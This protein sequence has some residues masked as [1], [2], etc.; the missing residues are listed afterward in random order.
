MYICI[1]DYEFQF[2]ASNLCV[3]DQ[4]QMFSLAWP[5]TLDISDHKVITCKD[6]RQ[7]KNLHFICLG[8]Q[9]GFDIIGRE[10]DKVKVFK[11]VQISNLFCLC[12]FCWY[13]VTS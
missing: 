11:C 9:E 2:C 8:P 4:L 6:L 5:T 1:Y 10:I 13:L 7:I 12:V 3:F